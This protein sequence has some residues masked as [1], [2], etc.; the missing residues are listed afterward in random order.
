MEDVFLEKEFYIIKMDLFRIDGNTKKEE[1]FEIK[2]F[3][4]KMILFW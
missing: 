4:F 1:E 3:K 2:I